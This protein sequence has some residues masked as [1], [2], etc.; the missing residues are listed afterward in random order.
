MSAARPGSASGIWRSMIRTSEIQSAW[1]LKMR[2]SDSSAST[3]VGSRF[4][5]RFPGVARP[6][7]VAQLALDQPRQLAQVLRLLRRIGD[8]A[9][10]L[11]V[12]DPRQVLPLVQRGVD[13]D[14]RAERL[15]VVRVEAHD[16]LEPARR[17]ARVLQRAAHDV[18]DAAQDRQLLVWVS[19]VFGVLIEHAHQLLRVTGAL[20]DPFQAR[21][22]SRSPGTAVRISFAA[23][24]PWARS[25][26]RSSQITSTRR[27]SPTRSC[28]VPARSICSRSSAARLTKSP[29]RS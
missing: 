2:A 18:G 20:E 15:A 26:V 29:S 1:L 5:Q 10:D 21:S 24:C 12:E 16:L 13:L 22:V 7:Q 27:S 17:A 8:D 11:E 3:S 25:P 4:E 14:Q 28:L 9:L 19:R 23:H 6:S